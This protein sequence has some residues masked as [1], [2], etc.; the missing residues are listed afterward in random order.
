MA[1]EVLRRRKHRALGPKRRV[2]WGRERTVFPSA[3]TW[4]GESS[5]EWAPEQASELHTAKGK[6]M[7]Q[8]R[9]C[10]TQVPN[11]GAEDGRSSPLSSFKIGFVPLGPRFRYV[12]CFLRHVKNAAN[13]GPGMV[14][15]AYNPS[16]SVLKQERSR[17]QGRPGLCI[18]QGKKIQQVS[19]PHL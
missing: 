6:T 3:N 5:D 18:S 11:E 16:F 8:S 17:G 4:A 13:Q 12:S 7:E 2:G 14:V 15:C 9:E 19:L 10:W 1:K